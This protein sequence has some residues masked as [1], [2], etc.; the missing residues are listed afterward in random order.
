MAR[1]PRNGLP[2]LKS[3][4]MIC[5]PFRLAFV[6]KLDEYIFEIGHERADLFRVHANS[7]Q[8]ALQLGLGDLVVHERVDGTAEDGSRT[9]ERQLAGTPQGCGYV[10]YGD[11][12]P[13]RSRGLHIG[14][15]AK[16]VWSAIGDQLAVIDVG[17][18]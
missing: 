13:L 2:F 8:F 17:E 6:G 1:K 4:G 5:L 9:Y 11:F 18:G 15:L 10:L 3:S 14:D 16:R 12:E 7:F